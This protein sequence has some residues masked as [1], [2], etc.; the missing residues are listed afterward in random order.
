MEGVREEWRGMGGVEG[1][2]RSG[3]GERVWEE[4][5]EGGVRWEWSG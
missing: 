3:G 4:G 1:Y 2:G 5:R